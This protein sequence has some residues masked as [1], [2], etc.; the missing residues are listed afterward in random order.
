[1]GNFGAFAN[2]AFGEHICFAL[3]IALVVQHLQGTQQRIGTVVGENRAVGAAAQQTVFF[4]EPVVKVV[5]AVG[6]SDLPAAV[7]RRIIG[8]DRIL[9]VSASSLEE[10]VKAEEDGADYLGVGA[11]FATGT[12]TDA[13]IVSIDELRSIKRA[14]SI[15]VVAIGGINRDTLP[16]FAGTGIDGIAVVSALISARDITGAARELKESFCQIR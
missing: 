9:G 11:M 16:L 4:C 6:Q 13:R 3:Q 14:V 2:R 1:M 5:Q 12:K 8:K 7:V 15:P 10:A